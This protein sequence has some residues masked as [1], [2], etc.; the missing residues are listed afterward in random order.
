VGAYAWDAELDIVDGN[1]LRPM[2]DPV[3]VV[4]LLVGLVF[5][6]RERRNPVMIAA[7]LCLVILPLPAVLQRGSIMRQPVGAAPYVALIAALPLAFMW[8]AALDA[9]G[10][11]RVAAVALGGVAVVLLV[12]TT[13]ITVHDYFWVWRKDSWP[14][15]IYHAPTTTAATYLR[16]LPGDDDPGGRPFVLYY[17]WQTPIRIE[18]IQFLAPDVEG[19]DRSFEYSEFGGSIEVFDRSRPTVFLLMEEYAYLLPEIEERYPGGTIRRVTRDGKYEFI[20]YELPP[21]P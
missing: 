15:Y 2:F 8:R 12:A 14:R 20:A 1:G 4:L 13:T 11:R 5:A 10:N 18:I 7:L 3:V 9:W 16:D 17:S 21:E 19:S 6:V